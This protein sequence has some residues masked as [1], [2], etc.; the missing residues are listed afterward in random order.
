MQFDGK[1]V[2]VAG[3]TGM[4][5]IPLVRLLVE[6]GAQV[7][8]SSLDS[9][10]RAHP[11]AEF[12]RLDLTDMA[13]CRAACAGMDFV[14][15]LLGVKAS[16]ALTRT[17]PGR[18][19]YNTVMMEFSMLEAARLEGVA[20][21][22]LTSSVGVYAP[23]EVF[24]EDDVWSTFPSP[25]DWYSG[26]SKRVGELQVEAYRIEYG[27][28][29]LTITRP[30]N[31]YGPFDNFD[32]ENAMVVPSLIKRALTSDGTL[33]VWGDGSAIR[34]FIFAEDVAAGMLRVAEAAPDKPVNLG[35]G[36]GYSIR[37]LVTAIA[38]N[39]DN[40]P[41][42]HWDTTKP[43]GDARR[44]LDMD[45][46]RSLGFTPAT[47]LTEGVRRTMEWYAANRDATSLRYD[48]YGDGK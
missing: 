39:M 6:R 20:G 9:P 4:I 29:D 43:T 41:E 14:F 16:P 18:F 35:S 48:V 25:N 32:S 34:D 7:R 15:N 33:S 31:V 19:L 11:D 23:A 42:I 36:H 38:A 21:Y 40:P 10:E 12:L 5:G 45:R 1:K 24:A 2:L 28:E 17:K 3:G 37:E 46:A 13:N 26:W 30:A 8:I 47:S 27:M 22:Q 44:I